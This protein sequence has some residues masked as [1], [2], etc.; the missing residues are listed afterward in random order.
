MR[1]RTRDKTPRLINVRYAGICSACKKRVEVGDEALY[2]PE[3]RAIE[4]R[5]CATGTLD[6]LADER[7]QNR[8]L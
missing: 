4:C 5:E 8:S 1:R 3:G 7:L 2:Y 6:A